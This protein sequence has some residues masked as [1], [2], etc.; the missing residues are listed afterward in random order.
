LAGFLTDFFAD[1]LAIFFAG[2]RFADARFAGARFV[3]RD[4]AGEAFFRT[5][6]LGEAFFAAFR[7]VLTAARVAFFLVLAP[8]AAT[9]VFLTVDFAICPSSAMRRTH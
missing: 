1:F 7:T 5:A 2:I 9:F 4:F 3:T 6:R 8:L